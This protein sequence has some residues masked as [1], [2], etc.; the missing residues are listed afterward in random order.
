MKRNSLPCLCIGAGVLLGYL[1]A[2]AAFGS[3]KPAEAGTALA[4][5]AAD[6]V[7]QSPDRPSSPQPTESNSPGKSVCCQGDLK[8]GL[9]V[10][11]NDQEVAAVSAAVQR[12][13]GKKPNIVVIMGDDI[14]M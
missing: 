1:A 9:L 4:E 12:R 10:A 5:V 7:Q 6:N 11:A 8:A 14:G 13:T 2:N 3:S